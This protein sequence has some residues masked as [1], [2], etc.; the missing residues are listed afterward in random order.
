MADADDTADMHPSVNTQVSSHVFPPP[1][2]RDPI[3]LSDVHI[4][5]E[6]IVEVLAQCWAI[7]DY[8]VRTGIAV[9]SAEPRRLA[10]YTVIGLSSALEVLWER[11]DALRRLQEEDLSV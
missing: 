8:D 7:R 5:I 9:R 4:G 2:L 1:H 6:A 11:E 3:G 10:L